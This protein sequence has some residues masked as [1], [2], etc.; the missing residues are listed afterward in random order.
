MRRHEESTIFPP[1][2][3]NNL[4]NFL[5]SRVGDSTY[6]SQRHRSADLAIIRSLL[7]DALE[8]LLG[9][10]TGPL[11]SQFVKGLLCVSIKRGCHSTSLL[12]ICQLD[13]VLLFPGAHE[14]MLEYRELVLIVLHII[15]HL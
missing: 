12:I 11:V 8:Q 5:L 6:L 2:A 4:R 3:F 1:E 13:Q 14:R 7:G 15:E 10:V 9:D